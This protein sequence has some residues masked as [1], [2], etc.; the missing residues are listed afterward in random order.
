AG[1]AATKTLPMLDV[2]PMVLQGCTAWTRSERVRPVE[3][4]VVGTTAEGVSVVSDDATLANSPTAVPGPS[5]PPLW[6][7]VSARHETKSELPDE[8]DC[9]RPETAGA[10]GAAHPGT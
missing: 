3:D 8:I 5:L 1:V 6:S 4:A 10:P 2:A 7:S 9:G